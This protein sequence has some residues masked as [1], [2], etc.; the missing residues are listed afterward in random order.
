MFCNT[1][2][3]NCVCGILQFVTSCDKVVDNK[4]N[5]QI[6]YHIQSLTFM[7]MYEMTTHG[8]SNI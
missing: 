3:N 6:T 4:V 7:A 8:C 2:L 5:F 1:V